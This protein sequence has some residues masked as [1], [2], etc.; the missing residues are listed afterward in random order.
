MRRWLLLLIISLCIVTNL[1]AQLA[2]RAKTLYDSAYAQDP[3]IVNYATSR[4]AQIL[5]TPDSNTFY[6]QWFP[7]STIPSNTPIVVSLHGSNCNAFMEFKSWFN[8]AQLHG[9]GIIAL[10]WYRYSSTAPY[11]YLPD[12]TLYNYIDSIL[13]KINYPTNKALLHGFSRG[14]ARSYAMIFKDI[15]SGKNYFCTTVC[16]AGKAD[17]GYPLYNSINSGVYGT[18]VFAGKHFNLFCGPPEPP[19]TGGAC[20]GL[21]DTKVWLESQGAT[22]DLFLQDSLLGHNGFQ[23]PSSDKYKDSF[24]NNYL[25]CY[26]GLLAIGDKSQHSEIS[27]YP[28]PFSSSTTIQSNEQFSDATLHI[29][30]IYGQLM[31]QI[32]P[33]N[34]NTFILESANLSNGMYY[35]QVSEGGKIRIKEK[36]IIRK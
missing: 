4:G 20:D 13:T 22:V 27:I 10:Q 36:V 16:N 12:D 14:S 7:T 3:L 34:G 18:N 11:D 17:L 28:N 8:Q 23:I 32:A 33:I 9:C 31:L 2:G 29:Y 21:S 24:L 5:S 35:L 1:T 26:N 19:Y 15:Q 6:I 30:N 25:K